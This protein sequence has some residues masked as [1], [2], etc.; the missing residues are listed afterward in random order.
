MQR[1]RRFLATSF[2]SALTGGLVVAVAGLLAIALGL[3]DTG[4]DDTATIV[5][6]PLTQAASSVQQDG[7]TAGAIYRR[8]NDGV[9]YVKAQRTERVSSPFGLLPQEQRSTATGSGFVI[10]QDGHILTNA[11]VVEGA[12]KIEVQIGD[13]DQAVSATLVGSDP[14]SDVAVLDVDADGLHPLPL[15]DPGELQVGDPVVAIGNPYGLDRTVTSGIVSALQREIQAPNGFSIDNVIQTDAAINPGNSGGP[16]IDAAGRVVG[17]N[18]QIA[19]SSGGSEGVGFAIPIDTAQDVA[20]Q[21]IEHGEVQ[22]AYLGISGADVTPEIASA[23]DLPV[24]Q[25]AMVAEALNGGPASDAGIRG[26]GGEASIGGQR[27][28]I[29]GDIIVAIDG[30]QVSGMDEV[31]QAVDSH[32]PGDRI[33]LTVVRNRERRDVEVELGTRPSQVQDSSVPSFP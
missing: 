5:Q 11:H 25:G 20:N 24:K 22:H 4:G 14:S 9:V 18:S 10:D 7:L 28:P 1:A 15:G 29:G 12:N 16:L 3:I 30:K 8:D 13:S 23:L 27:F 21:I 26:A 17:I 31:T 19:S 2:G 32:Q 6:P 33:T